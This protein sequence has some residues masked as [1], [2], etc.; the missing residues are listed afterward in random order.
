MKEL[1][2]DLN[3]FIIQKGV[4]SLITTDEGQALIENYLLIYDMVN[5]NSDSN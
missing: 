4:N 3:T 2:E 1:L 5:N